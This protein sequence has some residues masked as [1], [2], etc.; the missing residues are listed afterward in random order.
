MWEYEGSASWAPPPPYGFT[1]SPG[2]LGPRPLGRLQG[3][4][5]EGTELVFGLLQLDTHGRLGL[6]S[7]RSRGQST[8]FSS[9]ATRQSLIQHLICRL[10]CRIA[11]VEMLLQLSTFLH[12]SANLL[13]LLLLLLLLRASRVHLRLNAQRHALCCVLLEALLL[14]KDGHPRHLLLQYCLRHLDLLPLRHLDLLPLLLL[15][16]HLP[17]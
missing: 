4:R 15:L 12:K 11:L 16:G 5:S 13:L 8:S 10:A 1:H 17:K 6:F 2:G 14:F 3:P 9:S 7:R